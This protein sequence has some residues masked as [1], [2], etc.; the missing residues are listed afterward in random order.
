MR[1]SD[2]SGVALCGEPPAVLSAL[3]APGCLRLALHRVVAFAEPLEVVEGVGAT[4]LVWDDVVEFEVAGA[5]AA[6]C[7]LAFVVE[8]M[9]RGFAC[10]FPFAC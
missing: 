7:A 8:F 9:L 5:W 1:S 4:F 2:E 6:V 3:P 10:S